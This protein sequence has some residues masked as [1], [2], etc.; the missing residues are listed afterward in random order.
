MMDG[1]LASRREEAE[2]EEGERGRPWVAR[3]ATER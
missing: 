1:G 3:R 2:S